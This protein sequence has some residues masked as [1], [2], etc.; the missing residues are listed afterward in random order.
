MG[1]IAPGFVVTGD[2]LK[3]PDR[4]LVPAQLG[5]EVSYDV[6]DAQVGRIAREEFLV[7]CDGLLGPAGFDL[8]LGQLEDLRLVDLIFHPQPAFPSRLKV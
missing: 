1:K 4:L 8:A 2:G 3:R 7:L 6:I 5:V